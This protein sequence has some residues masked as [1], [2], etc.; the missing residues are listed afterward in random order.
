MI[1]IKTLVACF[2]C[3]ALAIKVNEWLHIFGFFDPL[4]SHL[5]INMKDSHLVDK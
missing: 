4:K 2:V 1:P 3:L 5:V